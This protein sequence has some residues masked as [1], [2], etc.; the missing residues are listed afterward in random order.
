MLP[1]TCI[2]IFFRNTQK[3]E[4]LNYVSYIFNPLLAIRENE[5]KMLSKIRDNITHILPMSS[6][7]GVDEGFSTLFS[8]A[9]FNVWGEKTFF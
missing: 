9:K 6:Y 8:F 1:L 3:L 2:L 4:Q 7:V 5:L